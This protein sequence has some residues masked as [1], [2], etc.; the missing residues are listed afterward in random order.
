MS[1]RAPKLIDAD[2]ETGC[3]DA[4]SLGGAVS[5]ARSVLAPLG[6]AAR[7]EAE[8][9]VAHA[10]GL[11]RA[12]VYAH[13]EQRLSEQTLERAHAAVRRRATGEPLS[14]IT[15]SREFWSMSL[16]VSSNTLTPRPETEHLVDRALQQIR[17]DAPATVLDAGTGSGAIAIAIAS[18][19]R[20]ADICAVD[21][22]MDAL[23][24]A[25]RNAERHAPGRIEFVHASWFDALRG[26][27]FDL[28]V[29]NPPYVEAADPCLQASPLRF[30]PL[31]ALAAGPQGLDAI[32]HIVAHAPD[33]L[34]A[35]G[36][37]LIEHGADQGPAV[38]RL[39]TLRDFD[40]VS[41][42]RDYAGHE[43]VTSG[44]LAGR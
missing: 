7:I 1:P 23:G 4:R 27:R 31:M 20:H 16:E 21:V 41:T 38:R 13:P 6:D 42:L 22:S 14:H 30:E 36:W 10:A 9:L 5:R 11:E 44:R 26:R 3:K 25:R 35:E 39:M 17:A 2:G 12:A 40:Q 34:H 8:L 29:S 24:V 43:R 37:L 18:E 32:E 28:I 15:G 19:R 33:H